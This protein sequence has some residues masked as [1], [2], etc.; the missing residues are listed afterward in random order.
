VLA[1]LGAR[2]GWVMLLYFLSPFAFSVSVVGCT[3]DSNCLYISCCALLIVFLLSVC[4]GARHLCIYVARLECLFEV[5][6]QCYLS[7]SCRI[8]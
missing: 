8:G 3:V 7:S 2:A 6:F 1:V 4:W 5:K